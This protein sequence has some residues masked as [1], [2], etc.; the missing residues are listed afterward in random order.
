MFVRGLLLW[1]LCCLEAIGLVV[2]WLASALDN[3]EDTKMMVG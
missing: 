1:R 3:V 2:R